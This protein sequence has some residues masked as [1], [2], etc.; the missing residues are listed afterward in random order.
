MNS[1]TE[2]F[3]LFLFRSVDRFI[4]CCYAKKSLPQSIKCDS[5]DDAFSSCDDLMKNEILQVFVWVLAFLALF[6]N[7]AVLLWRWSVKEKNRVQSFLLANLAVADLLMS[8]YLIII[9]AQDVHWRGEYFEHDMEWRSGGL[10]KVA[11][12]FSMLSSEVS[13]LTLSA[14]TADRF[15]CIVFPFS[16]KRLSLKKTYAICILMWIFGVIISCLPMFNIDYFYDKEN[17]VSFFG[18]SSVCL[19]LHLSAE[20]PS[21]YEYSV[22]FF[23][24]LNFVSFMFILIAYI[25]MFWRVKKSAA[26]AGSRSMKKETAMAKRVIFIIMTDFCCWMPVI[27]IGILS[28][29]DKFYDP[30]KEVYVWIAVFVLPVNSSINPILYTFSTVNI[31]TVVAKKWRS[32]REA[33]YSCCLKKTKGLFCLYP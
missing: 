25:A 28:L 21:G 29:F 16:S 33:F 26:A 15:I 5:P 14:I 9:A 13:V 2:L 20:R 3:C 8:V 19:P 31:K 6:G 24:G 30:K 18:R 11:G 32:L 17:G 27:I 12:M 4:Y 22:A 7:V 10:C 1:P 23:I